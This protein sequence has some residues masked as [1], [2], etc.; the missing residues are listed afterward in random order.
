MQPSHDL[1]ILIILNLENTNLGRFDIHYFLIS[2][3]ANQTNLVQDFFLKSKDRA[4]AE[5]IVATS[6]SKLLKIR[7]RSSQ[8]HY[9]VYLK[10][11]KVKRLV[12]DELIHG[13]QF[14]REL[15]GKNKKQFQNL[16]LSNNLEDI[17]KFETHL[18][19]HFYRY[20]LTR[21]DLS[22]SCTHWLVNSYRT[23]L[24]DHKPDHL[25]VTDY[26]THTPLKSFAEKESFFR[27]FQLIAFLRTNKINPKKQEYVGGETYYSLEFILSDYLQFIKIMAI[28]GKG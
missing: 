27:L 23:K 7:H 19:H 4:Q 15:K 25:L 24:L 20:S 10:E 12:Y 8:N 21:L 14:E 18:S 11:K 28:R 22:T 5:G 26:I 6:D 1:E 2:E 16:L 13:L 9:R 17:Q 3:L